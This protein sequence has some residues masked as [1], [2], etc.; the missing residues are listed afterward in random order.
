MNILLVD[1]ES[2]VRKSLSGFLGK[3]G[4]K[5]T[6]A[7]D[8][9]DGLQKFH[10]GSFDLVITDVRMPR[11]DGLELM[12]RIKQIE[13]SSADVIIITGHGDMGSA[14]KALKYGAYRLSS[15]AYQYPGAGYND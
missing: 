12:R 10:A 8:G 4:H 2:D 1:D 5:V 13:R 11:M 15:K 9:M 14:I 7:S 6:G 3:L